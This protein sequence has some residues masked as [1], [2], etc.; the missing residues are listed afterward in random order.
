MPKPDVGLVQA[1]KNEIKQEVWQ[2]NEEIYKKVETAI[3]E[4]TG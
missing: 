1:D 4:E 3:E 2:R